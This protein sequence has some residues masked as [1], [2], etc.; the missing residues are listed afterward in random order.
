MSVNKT[1]VEGRDVGLGGGVKPG[2]GIRRNQLQLKRRTGDLGIWNSPDELFFA[3]CD[4]KD[5]TYRH[6]LAITAGEIWAE[7]SSWRVFARQ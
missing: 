2:G 3:R 1:N 4:T 5:Q 7:S 6:V